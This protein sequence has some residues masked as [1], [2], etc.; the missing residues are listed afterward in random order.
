M[1]EAIDPRIERVRLL[2]ENRAISVRE[3]ARRTGVPASSVHAWAKRNG[4]PPRK[5]PRLL[6]DGSGPAPPL[7]RRR[8]RKRLSVG[9]LV[10]R[11]YRVITHNLESMEQRMSEEENSSNENPERE[12]RAISNI[13]R[14][15]EKLK[16]LEPDNSKRDPATNGRYP[17]TRDEEDRLRDEIVE[18]L[19]QLRERRADK[20]PKG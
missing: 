11:I 7:R 20:G 6:A 19:L 8:L 17:L 12:A 1:P 18:R 4:W 13:V 5:P 15:V 16:E 3:I 14:S 2:Y 10:D 9:R